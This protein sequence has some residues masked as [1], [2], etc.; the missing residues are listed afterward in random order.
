[1]VM[2]GFWEIGGAEISFRKDGRWY[3]DEDVIE[4]ARIALLF[5]KHIEPDGEGGWVIDVG[6]DRQPC[7]VDDTP[8]VIVSVNGNLQSGYS[9]RANDGITD[10]LDSATLRTGADNVLYCTLDRGERGC[11]DA[12]FLRPAY[13][14]LAKHFEQDADGF[15]L[16][17]AGGNVRIGTTVAG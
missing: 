17:V 6:V 10:T 15:L 1:M 5:S 8:L 4:N 2:A 14:E 12:R 7:K 13:Y 16:R 11:L 9:V 3:A